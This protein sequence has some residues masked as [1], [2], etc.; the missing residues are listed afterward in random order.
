MKKTL[1][2]LTIGLLT[3]ACSPDDSPSGIRSDEVTYCWECIEKEFI[4]S[5]KTNRYTICN[6]QKYIDRYLKQREDY[7]IIKCEKID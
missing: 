5:P 7:Y 1:T 3:F 4:Y 6:T 2:I